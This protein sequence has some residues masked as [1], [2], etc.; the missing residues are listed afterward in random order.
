MFMPELVSDYSSLQLDE[1]S[2]LAATE[3][4]GDDQPTPDTLADVRAEITAD[5]GVLAV[6]SLAVVGLA[7]YRMDVSDSTVILRTL[8][9]SNLVRGKGYGRL[10]VG[11]VEDQAADH[12]IARM[13]LR[14]SPEA[15]PF[16]Q[17]MGFVQI[18]GLYFEKQLR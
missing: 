5:T 15:V 9:T 4:L 11:H 3:L 8:A 13:G 1:A 6:G 16:Y 12:G 18:N 2:L 7:T 14:S 10:L 17:R